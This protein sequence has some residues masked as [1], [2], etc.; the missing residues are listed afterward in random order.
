MPN[1]DVV[2]QRFEEEKLKKCLHNLV[3]RKGLVGAAKALGVNF[4][5]LTGSIDSDKLSRRM[6]TALVRVARGR[7]L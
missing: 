4:R 3:R 7:G 2:P 1:V 5:A 6:R